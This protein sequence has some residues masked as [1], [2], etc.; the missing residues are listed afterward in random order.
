MAD[1]PF[2]EEY[3]DILGEAMEEEEVRK[4][5]EIKGSGEMTEDEGSGGSDGVDEAE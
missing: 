2:Y 5:F 4:M 3:K 1:K